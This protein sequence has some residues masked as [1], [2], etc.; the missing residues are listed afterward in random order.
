MKNLLIGFITLS[1]VSAFAGELINKS[2]GETLRLTLN[3]QTQEVEI[4]S[5]SSKL[6]N[7]KISLL[8][9]SKEESD[10]NLLSVNDAAS[11]NI[12][13]GMDCVGGD[14]GCVVYSFII[15]IYDIPRLAAVVAD[16]AV[17]PVRGP[18][19][20]IQNMNYNQD[21]AQLQRAINSSETITISNGR[22]QRIAELLSHSH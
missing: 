14:T 13:D 15:P 12:Y 9:I 3:A 21:F 20:L 17:L 16:A 1:T 22:F 8:R 10:I 4:L 5:S 2:T 18:I 11:D 19:K 7:K 6:A